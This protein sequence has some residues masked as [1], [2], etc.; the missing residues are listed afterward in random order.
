MLSLEKYSGLPIEIDEDDILQFG[1]GMA[2]VKPNVREFITVK[3]YLKNPLSTFPRREVYYIYRDVKRVEDSEALKNAGL[4][5]DLTVIPPGKI[6][7]EFVKTIGHYHA[8]KPGTKVRYP[9]VYEVVYGRA[10]FIL[11]SASEDFER[12]REVYLVTAR[13]GEKVMVPP[14]YGHMSI[15]PT[16]DALVLSNFQFRGNH[17]IYEP[18]E[19]HHGA[20]YY[21]SQSERLSPSGKTSLDYEF[22]PNLSYNALPKLE[23]RAPREMPQYDLLSAIP[24]Y[25]SALKNLAN[26]DFLKEPENYINDLVPEKMFR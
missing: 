12:L 16:Q 17:S 14:G 22:V 21:V 24:M 3:N 6:G 13:R 11:Q 7:E 1:P 5:Y 15:N 20:A 9:E 8:Y 25:F 2:A 19:A 4:Q 26:L 18:Y 10:F 23:H